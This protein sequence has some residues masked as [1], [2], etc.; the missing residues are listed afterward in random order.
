MIINKRAKAAVGALAVAVAVGLAAGGAFTGGGVTIDA[1][2]GFVGGNVDQTFTGAAVSA[3][4][5]DL[6]TNAEFI[7]GVHL[8][9]LTGQ[10]VSVA[11]TVGGTEGSAFS[12]TETVAASGNYDCTITAATVPVAADSVNFRV[13]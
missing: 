8:T 11:F 10:T 9:T 12:C 1:A 13:V 5:Y 2:S 4:T 6:D 7:V 3:V